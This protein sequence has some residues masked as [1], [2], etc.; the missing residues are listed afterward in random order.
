MTPVTAREL[1]QRVDGRTVTSLFL[2]RVHESPDRVALRWK[3]GD[4]W[5]EMTWR[6]WADQSAR[7]AGALQ[8]R[9]IGSGDRVLLM[10]RNRAEFHVADVAVLLTGATPISVY[11][12]SSAEQIAY[13]AGHSKARVA[14]VEDAGYLSRFVEVRS[15]LPALEELVLVEDDAGGDVRPWSGLLAHDPLDLD[16]AAKSTTPDDLATVIYTSGT[17]GPPK[18]VQITHRNVVWTVESYR[19]LLGDIEFLRIVSYLPM[20]HVAERLHGHYL[21]M[22]CGFEVTTCPDAGV[23]GSYATAVRPESMFGVPRVWEKMHAAAEGMLAQNEDLAKRFAEAR[24]TALPLQLARRFRDLTTDE[25][26]TLD[27]LDTS[28]LASARQLLGLDAARFAVTGAAPIPVEVFEWF[29]AIGVPFSEI[30]GMSENTGPLTWEAWKIK[31]GTVGKPLP[32]VEIRLAEDGEILARGGNIFPGYLDDPEKTAEALDP[33]GW[34]H[35]GDIGVFDDDGYL[36]IVDRKKELIIT[37]GGKNISP[38]NLESALRAIPLVGQACAIGDG[39]KFVSALITLDPDGV[40]AWARNHGQPDASMTELATDAAL[41]ADLTAAVDGAMADFNHA[42]QVKKFTILPDEWVP[43][44][45][46]LT[47][48]AKLKRRNIHTK[49]A[50]EIEAMYA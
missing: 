43:D 27:E 14:I 15:E 29:V 20:A 7:V 11:N 46:E 49:F 25:Q 12:S 50:A 19:A 47:P 9:G 32:G 34:L 10:L 17:T 8:D 30:Y 42:E 18:G 33:D 37:A 39:R 1:D 24:K 21:A 13:L 35:T 2:D 48:T 3:D 28:I 36:K 40:R 45:D 26:R 31:P 44:S 38:A 5:G 41:V 6:A 4:G 22:A 23:I 16:A